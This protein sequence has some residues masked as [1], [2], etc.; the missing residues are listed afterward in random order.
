MPGG[1]LDVDAGGA[2]ILIGVLQLR[3]GVVHAS[4][5]VDGQTQILGGA[6]LTGARRV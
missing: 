1:H 2:P 6:A 5:L 3:I 4:L